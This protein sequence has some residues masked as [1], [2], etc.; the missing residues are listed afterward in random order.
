VI[1]QFGD[2]VFQRLGPQRIDLASRW[3]Q[4]PERE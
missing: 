4:H 2:E 1:D 3:V